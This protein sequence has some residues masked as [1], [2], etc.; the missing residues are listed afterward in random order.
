MQPGHNATQPFP[1]VVAGKDRA[2]TSLISFF[3][4]CQQIRFGRSSRVNIHQ[5]FNRKGLTGEDPQ[6]I[7]AFA[8]V[9]YTMRDP[10][11][12]T[13]LDDLFHSERG[14]F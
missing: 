1:V 7:L 10:N 4:K 14:S 11:I 5:A 13:Q 6:L 2:A 12:G 8:K 3:E 9:T